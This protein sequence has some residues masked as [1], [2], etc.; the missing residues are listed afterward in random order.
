MFSQIF[1]NN[2][3]TGIFWIKY[4]YTNIKISLLKIIGPI[5]VIHKT[6]QNGDFSN[7][8]YLYYIN[9]LFKWHDKIDD[10]YCTTYNQ[11]GTYYYTART[12]L[13]DIPLIKTK[14]IDTTKRKQLILYD[15]G[16]IAKNN[17]SIVDNYVNTMKNINQK[18]FIKSTTVLKWLGIV[19]NEYKMTSINPYKCEKGSL[20]E[21]FL[22]HFY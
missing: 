20:E 19:A 3:L 17:I 7:I 2:L 13:T 1:F 11:W 6:N 22:E 9:K 15:N 8:T 18:Q 16:I 4:I 14:P 10:Y 12:T 5:Y 21:I